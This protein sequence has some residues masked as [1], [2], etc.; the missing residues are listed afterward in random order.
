VIK[1]P[2]FDSPNRSE[3][4]NSTSLSWS[5]SSNTGDVGLCGCV[6]VW[7]CGCM[8]V[9][10]Y[11]CVLW[12]SC[13]KTASK[14]RHQTLLKLYPRKLFFKLEFISLK[15]FRTTKPF[16]GFGLG[17]HWT[18]NKTFARN[19]KSEQTNSPQNSFEEKNPFFKV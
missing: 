10:L 8:K 2:W 18:V 5:L 15:F 1:G 17:Q 9:C 12:L 6:S 16:S 11:V 7:M 13:V 3:N 14:L 4:G 19:V